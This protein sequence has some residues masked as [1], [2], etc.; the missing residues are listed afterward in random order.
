M[1]ITE[2]DRLIIRRIT[3]NDIS[4][5]LKIYNKSENMNFISNGKS[6]WTK[7]ELSEKYNKVNSS[8]LLRDEIFAIELKKD[9]KIIGEA[10]LFNSFDCY[11]KLEL[12]YIIDSTFWKKGFGKET[13]YGLIKY[14]FINLKSE[15]L[16]ARMYAENISSVI[17]SE[18]CGMKRIKT[19]I[20]ENGKQF[21]IYEIKRT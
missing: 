15:T 19:G 20:A 3:K 21:Y 17:L 10:G 7:A 4:E 11:S 12:G 1:V 8:N 9:N 13:C 16:I 18:K 2:T 5:L 14:A 6:T